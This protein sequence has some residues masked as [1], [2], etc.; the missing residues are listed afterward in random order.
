MKCSDFLWGVNTHCDFY[1][2]YRRENAEKQLKLIRDMGCGIVRTN[3]YNFDFS[4]F[5]VPLANAYGLKVM[6]VVDGYVDDFSG[7]YNKETDFEL[8]RKVAERYDGNHGFG[9]IDFIQLNNEVDVKIGRFNPN[10][11]DGETAEE[12]PQ[13]IMQS[14][15]EHFANAAVGVRAAKTDVKIVINAGWKHY[16]MLLYMREKGID[17]DLVGWDWYTDMSKAM[18]REGKR[19][20]QIA[21]TLHEL[22]DK[23]IIVCETNTWTNGSMDEND[24]TNWDDLFDIINDAV[25][26]PYVKGLILY[27]CCDE[28]HFE[29]GDQYEREAHFGLVKSDAQGN[30]LE[31]KPVY[32][33]LKE[34]FTQNMR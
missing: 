21:E 3:F 26:Y 27:E 23:D 17:F 5:Y 25:N 8:F 19:A 13:P 16:G 10:F 4:D 9:K 18:I 32:Y 11:G 28:M 29:A 34:Y 33:K 2:V 12:F 7:G 22:F 15:Y 6:L 24:V 20:F 14:A 1:P 31:I 30:M